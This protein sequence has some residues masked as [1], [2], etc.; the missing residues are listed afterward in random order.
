MLTNPCVP[1]R[2]SPHFQSLVASPIR[3]FQAE[4]DVKNIQVVL[5]S[6][7]NPRQRLPLASSLLQMLTG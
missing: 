4:G 2:P 1:Y 7:T 6:A 3:G 5:M